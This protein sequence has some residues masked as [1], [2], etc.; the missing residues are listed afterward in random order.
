[1]SK[2]KRPLSEFK[3]GLI[4]NYIAIAIGL[5]SSLLLN[6]IIIQKLGQSEY[7]LYESIGS[8]VNNLAI[9]DLGFSSVIVRFTAKYQSEGDLKRRDEFLYTARR[10]YQILAGI[11]LAIGSVMYFLI[12]VTY[13]NSFTAEELEKAHILFLFVLGTTALSVYSQIYIGALSGIEK[14]IIPRVIRIAKTIFGKVVCIAV[15]MIGADSVGYTAV[16]FAFEILGFL[17]YNFY[18]KKS[19][20]FSKCKIRFSEVKELLVFTGFLFIQAIAAR[21]YWT[22]DKLILG[23]MMGTTV[24][25]VYSVAMNLHNIVENVSVSVRDVLL[26]KATRF[27]VTEGGKKEVQGFM[28]KAGRLVLMVYGLLFSGVLVLGKEFISL[29]IGEDY[30]GAYGIFVVLGATSLLPSIL[31]IGETVCRAFNKH[32]FLSYAYLVGALINVVLTI[33]FVSWWKMYGAAIATGIG[34]IVVYTIVRLV[35]FKKIFDLHIFKYLK[36]TFSGILLSLIMTVA[37]GVIVTYF[38]TDYSWFSLVIQACLMGGVFAVTMF[39]FGLN[40]EEKNMFLNI[41]KTITSKFIK[42]SN[43][44]K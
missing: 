4:L 34:L 41:M 44:S 20:N 12:D 29:W 43:L 30:L 15:I 3:L 13:K 18:A 6:P 35:Y 21:L 36:D 28:T 14:F 32:Q 31:S 5:V 22:V 11:V 42:K 26:P 1:M 27:A 33:V 25:A 16:L 17:A 39:M 2:V 10:I 8:F 19:V 7:G 38:W 37:F 24:V 9:L 40:K 23:A